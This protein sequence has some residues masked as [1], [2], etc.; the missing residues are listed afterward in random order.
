MAKG[1]I[2]GGLPSW[3]KGTIAVAVVAA[4][5]FVAYKLY[6]KAKDLAGNKDEKK[7]TNE[8]L[9][10][11]DKLQKQGQKLSKPIPAYQQL[12]NDIVVKLNGC[13]TVYTELDVIKAIIRI[14]KKPVD[15]YYLVS[16]F[17]NKKIEDCGTFGLAS[18]NYDLP[19]LLKDQLESFVPL[20]QGKT[21]EVDG[22]KGTGMY[23]K[24]VNLLNEYFKTIGVVM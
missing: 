11:F 2:F 12:I 9:T 1:E 5:A 3:A 15:W 4:G 17:G 21:F 10:E 8:N 22:F 20:L 16:K 6:K 14:V 13:E 18:T 24:S 19:T 23:R 7:V